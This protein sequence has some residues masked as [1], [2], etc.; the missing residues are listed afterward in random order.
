MCVCSLRYPA[1][2]THAPYYVVICGLS[3]STVFF[4]IISKSVD[5]SEGKLLDIKFV[6]DFFYKFSLKH[7]LFEEEFGDIIP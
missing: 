2:N 6:F 1:C 5:D 7:F 4:P 3:G